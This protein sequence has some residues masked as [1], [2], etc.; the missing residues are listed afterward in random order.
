MAV[1]LGADVTVVDRSAGALRRLVA[2]FGTRIKT[3]F[4][5][6]EMLARLVAEADLII[7]TI[8]IPGTAA[9]KLITRAMLRTM[10][11]GSPIVDVSIDQGGCEETSKPT[12]HSSPT[13]I[14]DGVVHYC[15]ANMPGGSPVRRLSRSTMPRCHSF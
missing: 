9:P 7:G 8:L 5:T 6:Q 2:Q 12:T 15:V 11:P 3:V 10:K 13:Y 14:V 1:G 4:P